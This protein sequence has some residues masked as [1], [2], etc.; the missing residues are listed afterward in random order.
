M[1]GTL[2]TRSKS[3]YEK[4]KSLSDYAFFLHKMSR[5]RLVLSAG[6]PRS[7]STLLFNILRIALSK[8]PGQLSS[9]WIGD[10]KSIP[11]GSTYLLKVHDIGL[12]RAIRASQVFYTYRDIRDAL[13]S[14]QRKFGHASMSIARGW[15]KGY[16]FAQKHATRMI[17][18]E[19]LT[20]SLPETI[21]FLLEDLDVASS[22]QEVIA[23]L[24]DQAKDVSANGYSKDSLLHADH[25]TNT[26][27]GE[28][29]EVLD[30]NLCDSVNAEFGWWFEENGYESS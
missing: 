22:V 16:Q 28:W 19:E 4:L 8:Q 9:G 3:M 29:R 21:A 23:E 2:D 25:R 1:A 17:S 18:Y 11:R 13:V 27:A 20:E 6:M 15:V 30:P 26:T 24:P 12:H 14:N 5:A 10:L 7:G